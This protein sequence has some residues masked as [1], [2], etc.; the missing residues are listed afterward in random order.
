MTDIITIENNNLGSEI[1]IFR[2]DSQLSDNLGSPMGSF[3][4]LSSE[5]SNE[6]EEGESITSITDQVKI[7]KFEDTLTDEDHRQF[8]IIYK[9]L[10]LEIKVGNLTKSTLEVVLAQKTSCLVT[11]NT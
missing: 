10:L 1:P 6:K 9:S 11:S 5:Q 2:Q 7:L 3:L 8:E 4:S